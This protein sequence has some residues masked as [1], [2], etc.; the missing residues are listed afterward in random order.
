MS[1]L[2]ETVGTKYTEM[3]ECAVSNLKLNSLEH[4]LGEKKSHTKFM[5]KDKHSDT[6]LALNSSLYYS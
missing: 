2:P 4:L 6:K 1:P 3:F 5:N